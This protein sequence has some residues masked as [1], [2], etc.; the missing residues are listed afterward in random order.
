MSLMRLPLTVYF[1]LQRPTHKHT[2]AD[3]TCPWYPTV[4]VLLLLFLSQPG[5]GVCS[6][7]QLRAE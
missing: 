3:L 5:G 7:Q 2:K 1:I 4:V 6:L